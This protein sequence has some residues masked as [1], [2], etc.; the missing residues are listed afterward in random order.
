MKYKRIKIFVITLL[1]ICTVFPAVT[2]ASNQDYLFTAQYDEKKDT[3]LLHFKHNVGT[4]VNKAECDYR[5]DS[6]SWETH[7]KDIFFWIGNFD[8]KSEHKPK[9]MKSGQKIEYRIKFL[10]GSKV[11]KEITAP[12]I[13]W[14]D[15]SSGSH[16]IAPETDNASINPDTGDGADW[17]ERLAATLIAAPAKW[18]LNAVGLYDPIDLVFGDFTKGI[19]KDY[20][21]VGSLP[22]LS[23]FTEKEWNALTEFY[24][25]VNE[26][27]PIE[28]VLV[29]VFM[30]I[31]YWYSATKP[32]ARVSF[33][34]CV[35]GLLVAML[36]L[37]MGGLMFGF[38]FDLNKL[39]VAQFYGAVDG[40]IAEG[41]SFLTSFI[42]LEQDG[43]IGSAI[44]F[45]I[46]V[47]TVSV[48]NWQYVIRKV[49]IAL[50]IGLLPVVA[51]IS[52]I[53]RESIVIWFRELIA[54]IFLQ[55]SHAAILG[56]LIVLGKS[57]GSSHGGALTT[58]QFWFTLVA[59]VSI[60]SMTVLIRKL[61][62]AEGVGTGIGGALSAG[63]GIG[64]ILAIGK[65]LG[66][67]KKANIPAKVG[68]A[69][70]STGG[71]GGGVKGGLASGLA[72]VGKGFA[73]TAG[74]LAGGM[75]AGPGGMALGGSL[76]AKGAGLFNDTASSLSQ[77]AQKTKSDGAL[78]AMGLSDKRQMLDPGSM[79]GAG[80]QILGD[81]VIGKSAG[82]LMAAGAGVAS[83]LPV[84]KEA[85]SVMGEAH[86]QAE[87]ARRS[88]PD[89]R[90]DMNNLTTQKE[91]AQARFDH[92]KNLYGPK[93]EKMQW[94]QEQVKQFEGGFEEASNFV[95]SYDRSVFTEQST[96]DK[97]SQVLSENPDNKAAAN[98]LNTAQESL[99]QL[100]KVEP[101]VSKVRS[102]V[103]HIDKSS[104][105]GEAKSQYE[106]VSA[107]EAETRMQLLQAQR[108]QTRD[109]LKDYFQKIN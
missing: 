46:G 86:K 108:K 100:Q 24:G 73:A 52:I 80:Q 57:S 75:I 72:K 6:G 42:S 102:A 21:R 94:A 69:D 95:S 41:A 67:G 70:A 104:E 101:K 22:Y 13:V 8:R 83:R 79:Y 47:L 53:K 48:I 20:Q 63:L 99:I 68:A 66:G 88:I 16:E 51:V 77:F 45:I 15:A 55:A 50:L 27:V 85:R 40:K 44:L 93:S 1:I 81:N 29:V 7:F 91:I 9:N 4:K 90:T 2:W 25:K 103:E 32:D 76:G 18:I 14:G 31:A 60:P 89:L 28:L 62:G 78:S 54:N 49:M 87:A 97:M 107:R 38:L 26:I 106:D 71:G 12:V 84:N 65:T 105:Y 74:G 3:V 82:T 5:I 56:F 92:A 37:R 34:G 59:L 35:A 109:G 96:V 61:L 11:V 98:R 10:K 33:R 30:G 39:L 19:S 64:S 58:S 17:A 36:L 43:Y 23:T